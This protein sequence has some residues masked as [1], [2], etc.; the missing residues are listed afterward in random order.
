MVEKKSDE[1]PL[2]FTLFLELKGFVIEF[3]LTVEYRGH[4]CGQ[5]VNSLWFSAF[6]AYLLE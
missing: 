2:R 4:G 1:T 6:T 5:S 3:A